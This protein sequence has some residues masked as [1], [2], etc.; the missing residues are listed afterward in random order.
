MSYE[1]MKPQ[2]SANQFFFLFSQESLNFEVMV[3]FRSTPQIFEVHGR[4]VPHAVMRM[5]HHR[6][7]QLVLIL[8]SAASSFVL[9]RVFFFNLPCNALDVASAASVEA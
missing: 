4:Q 9:Q 2:A 7:P 5:N 1:V 6:A 8:V 3:R